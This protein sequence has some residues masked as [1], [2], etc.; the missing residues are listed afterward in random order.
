MLFKVVG[1]AAPPS[2]DELWSSSDTLSEDI[3]AAVDTT[4][5]HQ[6]HY[7]NRIVQY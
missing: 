4:S 3:D 5:T 2:I 1:G 7:K 6:G